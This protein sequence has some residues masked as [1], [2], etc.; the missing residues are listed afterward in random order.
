MFSHSS[1]RDANILIYFHNNII[2]RKVSNYDAL[3]HECCQTLCQSLWFCEANSLQIPQFRR[4]FFA[5]LR[6]FVRVL[7]KFVLCMR[8]NRYFWA[9]P[10][11]SATSISYRHMVYAYFGNQTTFTVWLWPLTFWPLTF[12]SVW[13]VTWANCVLNLSKLE[14]CKAE[15]LIR[16]IFLPA[17]QRAVNV[18]LFSETGATK[19]T[20]LGGDIDQSSLLPM[21]VAD[22]RFRPRT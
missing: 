2:T 18:P 10:S 4:G 20:K 5:N 17:F 3:Q 15:L 19:C 11:D 22:F 1:C 13:T 7:A 14:Q 6:A 8:R 9:P 16:Q 12:Y 21:Y